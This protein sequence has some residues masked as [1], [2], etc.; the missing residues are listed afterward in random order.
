MLQRNLNQTSDDEMRSHP[1]E[2]SRVYRDARLV[3]ELEVGTRR[4]HV[5]GDNDDL[6]PAIEAN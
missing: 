3:I 4:Y 2:S 5:S 6:L 1:A